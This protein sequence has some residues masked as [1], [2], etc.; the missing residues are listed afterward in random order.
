M[1]RVH[2]QC[3][4]IDSGT[5]LSQT[6]SKQAECTECT[7]YWPNS[8]PRPRLLSRPRA[9]APRAP[10]PVPPSA[11]APATAPARP[12]APYA[13][14][15]PARPACQCR[16]ARPSPCALRLSAPHA[17]PAH[18]H[19]PRA[20]VP[21][22]PASCSMGSSPFQVLHIFFFSFFTLFFFIHFFFYATGKSPKKIIIYFYLFIIIIF[23]FPVHPNKFISIPQFFFLIFQ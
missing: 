20:Y 4:K 22:R 2:E 10:A 1:N 12:S 5:V 18:Q 11:P 13:L 21:A 17:Q 14:C 16:V 19:T 7:A 3:P 6:A 8:K 23:H 9:P 15:P